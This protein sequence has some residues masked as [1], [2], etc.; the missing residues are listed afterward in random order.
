MIEKAEDSERAA[1]LYS[2]A[3]GLCEAAGDDELMRARG[4][5]ALAEVAERWPRVA[6]LSGGIAT[7]HPR[8]RGR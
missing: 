2:L 6:E 1:L 4:L 8:Q 5:D 7:G 3:E